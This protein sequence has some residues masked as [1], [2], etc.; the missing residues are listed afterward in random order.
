MFF[1]CKIS[2]SL[3]TVVVVFL[4]T[5]GSFLISVLRLGFTIMCA[6]SVFRVQKDL[7]LDDQELANFGFLSFLGSAASSVAARV[8]PT[9]L[10]PIRPTPTLSSSPKPSC[11][12]DDFLFCF[13]ICDFVWSGLRKK[14]G[15][16]GW[17]F[18]F[19]FLLAVDYWWLW[20]W[21]M[22]E[23]VVVSVVNFFG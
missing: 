17:W 22:V 6:N 2:L 18:F 7:L 14:I 13:V 3:L 15:D 23:V 21:L 9:S 12:I 20:V 16:L 1:D 4:T 19:F 11:V 5:V 10:L 8:K